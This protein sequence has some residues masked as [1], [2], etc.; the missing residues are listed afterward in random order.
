MLLDLEIERPVAGGRML[1]RHEGQVVLVADAIPGERVRAHVERTQ[2]G[3]L[4][5]RVVE[6][7]R[8]DASRRDPGPDPSCGGMHYAHIALE[9]QRE[10]KAAVV[11]DAFGRIARHAIAPPAV[12]ASPDRAYRMRVRLH[13]RDGRLGSFREGTHEICDVRRTGQVSDATVDVVRAVAEA[14]DAGGVRRLEAVEIAENLDGTQRVVHLDCGERERVVDEA[15]AAVS[16]IA[17]VTGVTSARAWSRTV[18]TVSGVPWVSDLVTAFVG[19]ALGA[20]VGAA[21]RRHAPSFFQANRF[22]TA[23][24]VQR[25]LARVERGP[26]VDLYAGVG[27]FAL[28]AAAAGI[29]AVTAV[30]GDPVSA[31]DLATNAEPF[32]PAVTVAQQ[33]VEEFL[34]RTGSLSSAT[35]VVDP[36]RTGISRA[37]MDGILSTR[38]PRIVYVSCDV[39]TMARDAKRLMEAGYT[40]GEVE[41]FDLFPNTGHVEALA[42]F[43]M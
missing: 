27:L 18:R 38:A 9:R 24:L 2:R 37:A 32:G 36:P 21:L 5:A 15:L 26:L 34:A 3:V 30:E 35:L 16:A 7:L 12:H 33:P 4:F 41:A 19:G 40:M 39:A 23:T 6:V 17:G 13:V 28:S 1:A 20:P 10:L 42:A 43:G 14:L 29:G 11:V 31:S 8:A 22:L 25:V